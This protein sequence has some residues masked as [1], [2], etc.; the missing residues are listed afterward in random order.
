MPVIS[1]VIT[2]TTE[3]GQINVSGPIN[4]RL[5]SFGMLETAKSI[6]ADKHR[7]EAQRLV[8]PAGMGNLMDFK[9]PIGS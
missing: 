1:L 7:E 8:Q 5:L 2:F 6:V 3:T 4:D 9:K